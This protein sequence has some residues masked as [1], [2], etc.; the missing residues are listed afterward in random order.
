MSEALLKIRL[1][2]LEGIADQALKAAREARELVE[3]IRIRMLGMSVPPQGER[4]DPGPAGIAP[5]EV[6]DMIARLDAL[7]ALDRTPLP[8]PS[9]TPAKSATAERFVKDIA[10]IN[11]IAFTAAIYRAEMPCRLTAIRGVVTGGG[12]A[13]FNMRKLGGAPHMSG[14]LS[15]GPRG[16]E[17]KS[18]EGQIL[19]PDY[20]I[21]ETLEFELLDTWLNPDAVTAQAEFMRLAA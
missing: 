1:A 13:R 7:E 2:Q 15:V 14:A 20:A 3:N 6:G 8:S 5:E 21:G 10:M 11:P 18:F 12:S 9:A 19:S 16:G 17:W 4:G